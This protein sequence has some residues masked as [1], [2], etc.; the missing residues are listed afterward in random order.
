MALA[1]S[2]P[3]E[4]VSLYFIL[5]FIPPRICEA[6]HTFSAVGLGGRTGEVLL[7][8]N[9]IV[10]TL[11]PE[12]LSPGNGRRQESEKQEGLNSGYLPNIY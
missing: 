12:A 1:I 8:G 4:Y 10:N 11:A 6:A 7:S 9:T 5:R 3:L 2:D